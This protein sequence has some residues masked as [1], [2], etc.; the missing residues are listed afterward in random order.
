MTRDNRELDQ[1]VPLS[2]SPQIRTLMGII[3][4]LL[5]GA[6]LVWFLRTRPNSGW[7]FWINLWVPASLLVTGQSPYG[8]EVI[9]EGVNA[10]WLTH[11]HW[12]SVSTGLVRPRDGQQYLVRG[13]SN[14]LT[15]LGHAGLRQKETG[16]DPIG[17]QRYHRGYI[18]CFNCPSKDRSNHDTRYVLLLSGCVY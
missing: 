7:D 18:S 12:G 8:V 13:Q 3:L 6:L 17:H 2:N 5:I 16:A 10:V 1:K 11:G 4:I 15:G 9:L 14:G